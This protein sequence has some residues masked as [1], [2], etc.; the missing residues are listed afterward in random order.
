[1]EDEILQPT[2]P[3][4]DVD[5]SS[6]AGDRPSFTRPPRH[7]GKERKQRRIADAAFAS[8][9]EDS[10]LASTRLNLHQRCELRHVPARYRFRFERI[11]KAGHS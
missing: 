1:M 2:W 8:H 9:H 6:N 5:Y 11:G 10:E 4:L 7:P 3:P